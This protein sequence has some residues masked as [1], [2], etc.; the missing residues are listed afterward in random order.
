MFLHE[1]HHSYHTSR[2]LRK[3]FWVWLISRNHVVEWQVGKKEVNVICCGDGEVSPLIFSTVP[4]ARHYVEY[5]FNIEQKDHC[6]RLEEFPAY[7]TKAAKMDVSQRITM[8]SLWQRGLWLEMLA[9]KKWRWWSDSLTNGSSVIHHS[10]W[11]QKFRSPMHLFL[12]LNNEIIFVD[13]TCLLSRMNCFTWN[14][15]N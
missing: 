4:T 9:C 14:E 15:F 11:E 3:L 2:S 7:I 6:T 13:L 8:Q 10:G 5:L 1:H 12:G